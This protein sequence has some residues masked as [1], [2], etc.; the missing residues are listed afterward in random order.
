MT[1]QQ[2]RYVIA[3]ADNKSINKAALSLYITQ[4]SLSGAIKELE[5]EIG[6]KIFTR[7]SRGIVLTREGEEFLGYARQMLEYYRLIEDRY[8]ENKKIKKKFSVSSQ[9]YTFAVE[10]FV[11][12]VRQ[13][14]MDEYEFDIHE[15]KTYEVIENVKNLKSE[16]GILYINDF[17]KQVLNKILRKE[18]LE[19]IPL[20]DCGIYVYMSSGNPL[21]K[22]EIINM[23]DLDEYPCLSFDQGNYNSFYFSEEALSTLDYKKMIKCSD[24]AT[25]LNMMSGLNGYTICCG[26]ICEEL[27]GEGYTAIPLDTDEKM[28]IGYVKRINMPLTELGE[29]YIEELKKYEDMVLAYN[30]GEKVNGKNIKL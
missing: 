7:T 22:K 13:Y 14:G 1:L 18:E 10:A 17:N 8:I 21:A 16:L 12:L 26:I 5:K 6:M 23:E 2:L 28:T 9:H 27:N 15:T 19:F 30:K 24:R 25:I 11:N 4:P 3:V 20:L 29:K